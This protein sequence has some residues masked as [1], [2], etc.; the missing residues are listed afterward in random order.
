MN[1]IRYPILKEL[2][3]LNGHSIHYVDL[4]NRLD[5]PPIYSEALLCEMQK[6]GLISG[7]LSSGGF[8]GL[9]DTGVSLYLQRTLEL[10]QENEQKAKQEKQQSFQNKISV[11]SVLVPL[12]TFILGL[13]VEYFGGLLRFFFQFF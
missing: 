11:A 1:D 12:V 6:D 2:G 7:D 8:I 13:V 4:L 10:N 3:S 9:T 5:S